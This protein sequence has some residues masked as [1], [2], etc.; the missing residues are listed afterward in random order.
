MT[1]FTNRNLWMSKNEPVT[2]VPHGF[3]VSNLPCRSLISR[4]ARMATL[5]TSDGTPKTGQVVLH[6]AVAAKLAEIQQLRADLGVLIEEREALFKRRDYILARYA[7][8]VGHLEYE[9]YRVQV[10]VAEL[11]YRIGFLQRLINRGKPV[12]TTDHRKLDLLVNQE[13]E[14]SREN[15]VSREK[16]LRESEGYLAS[17][18]EVLA[19]DEALELKTLYR[20]L[21]MKYH[22]DM[23]GE[24]HPQWEQRWNALQYAYR[25]GDLELLRALAGAAE[26]VELTP[27]DDLHAEIKRLKDCLEAQRKVIA[28]MLASPPY[29]Y[30]AQ[31]D[32][33]TW[34]KHKQ[35]ELKQARDEAHQQREQLQALHDSLLANEGSVH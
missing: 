16:A 26:E 33:A 20:R 21:C 31:L 23:G 10:A 19:D 4:K 7:Q 17:L 8:S 24:R 2:I 9:L 11:R 25:N 27:P 15:L 3:K 22:P 28:E 6:P 1:E 34:V 12:T 5:M 14:K 32:D 29:T 18:V 35:K 30:E 13:F